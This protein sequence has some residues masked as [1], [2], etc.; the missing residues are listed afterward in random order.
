MWDRMLH[1]PTLS[2][3]PRHRTDIPIHVDYSLRVAAENGYLDVVKYLIENG[4]NPEIIG[5]IKD[6]EIKELLKYE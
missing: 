1:N 5:D 4:A 6:S 3:V 2:L